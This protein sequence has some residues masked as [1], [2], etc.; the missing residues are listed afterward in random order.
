MT[1]LAAIVPRPDAKQDP[2][3]LARRLSAAAVS[4]D[5]FER[6]KAAREATG[7]RLAFTT[8]FGLPEQAICHAIGSQNLAIDLGK[9]RVV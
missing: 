5:L 3:V 8:S 9:G 2:A 6:V 4:Q 7:G 1:A